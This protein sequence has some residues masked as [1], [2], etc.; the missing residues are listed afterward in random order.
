MAKSVTLT[1]A[2]LAGA[3]TLALVLGHTAFAQEAQPPA[4]ADETGAQETSVSDS[5]SEEVIVTATGRAAAVQKIPVA[6]SIVKEDDL[7]KSGGQDLRDISQLVPSIEM[8]PGATSGST[9]LRLRGIGT[10]SDNPGFESA[11]G[12]FVDGVY[13][14]RPG[15]ALSDLPELKRIEVLRGP[16]GT[17]FGRN[18]SAGAISVI[19]AGPEFETSAYAETTFGLDETSE[20]TIR[21]GFTAPVSDSFAL[22]LDGA[23]R[24][25]DGFITDTISGEKYNDR[26]RWML[27]GQALWDISENAS[28]RIIVDGARQ[29]ELCCGV[30]PLAYG[31]TQ[32]V[33][34]ALLGPSASPSTDIRRHE[35]SVTPALP[36]LPAMGPG[37]PAQPATDARGQVDLSD[38]WGMS[39][40]LDWDLGGSTF[41]SITA[42]RDWRT[43]RDQDIDYNLIDIAYRDDQTINFRN[44]S[45]E[46]RLQGENDWVN[47]LVGAYA[48]TERM[49]TTDRIRLGSYYNLYLN[50]LTQGATG[51]EVYDSSSAAEPD[52]VPS[53]FYCATGN[54]ALLNTYLQG[55]VA[56]QGQQ[57][58]NWAVDS[59]SAS[60]FTHDEFKLTDALTLTTGLRY[61]F[62]RKEMDADLQA[63]SDSC[64]SLQALETATDP[65]IPGAG[66]LVTALQ[67]DPNAGVIMGLAC[68]PAVNPIANGVWGG[69]FSDGAWSGTASLSYALSEN[70]MLY[71]TVSRGFKSGGYN[72]DRSGFA[73]TPALTDPSQLSVDQLRF[74]PEYTNAYEIGVKSTLWGNTTLNATAYI[75]RIKGFQINAFNGFNFRTL[76]VPK[77]T[78]QGFELEMASHPIEGLTLTAGLTYT[79]VHYDSTITFDPL[80]PA[81]S[82]VYAGD[83]ATVPEWTATGSVAYE[84]PVSTALIAGIYL[85]AR[86]V[87]HSKTQ[88]LNRDPR[89]DNNAFA[90]LNG[91]LSLGDADGRWGVD[92]WCR[93]LTD[94]VF[95]AGAFK[96]PLQ[97]TTVVI[98][99]E[100]R[101]YGL[102]LRARF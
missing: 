26:D 44:F 60:L 92:L 1:R 86:W 75:E 5:G 3:S 18:T 71:A 73:V 14:P 38:E 34:T 16:Q 12:V 89:T 97:D 94:E 98:T 57:A 36:G 22:R 28:L 65:L 46:F 81:T 47:W 15:A 50:T 55:N 76:N 101:T 41:T 87:G 61:N 52:S 77:V 84:A 95:Y 80:N 27:R 62:E 8:G 79:D 72:V 25:R 33:V 58:D 59:T 83:R 100:P 53:F 69:S 4:P 37:L 17:L 13:R 93:N 7:R 54:P 64:L 85:D 45:Q 63:T 32:G 56:G 102:T 82:T 2:L 90:I 48:G 9:A 42:Y 31:A 24:K 66:G 21:G 40:Q 10:G 39:A 88:T 23:L 6:V 19:T 11:V 49:R 96:A 35:M 70:A 78:S 51:C 43:S 30:S 91:R 29:D 68:N 20:R 67:T 74:D 99:N